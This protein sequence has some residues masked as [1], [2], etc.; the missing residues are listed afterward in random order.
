MASSVYAGW[1]REQLL[2]RVAELEK[3]NPAAA[4]SSSVP[5][6]PKPKPTKPFD[7]YS[8]PRRKI[9]LK[10][11]YAGWDYGGLAFQ[12]DDTPL[13]TVE[14]VL[15]DALAKAHLVDPHNQLGRL[16]LGTVWEDGS[17]SQWCQAGGFRVALPPNS[18]KAL[19]DG[20]EPP[21]GEEEDATVNV[22]ASDLYVPE[23]VQ[24][25][26]RSEHDYVSIL[27]RLLPETI[28][29]SAW[30]PVPSTFSARFSCNFR[31]YKYFFSPSGLNI[32]RMREGA[33]R[34]VGEHDFRNLCKLDP[35]KQIT[36]FK[37]NVMSATIDQLND[38][39]HVF[40]LTGSAFLYHQVR[41]IMA[42][43]FLIGTG[44]EQP[45]LV[46]NL[47]NVSSG[48]EP[49]LEGDAP[50]QVVDRK[51]EY[52]MADGLP[53]LLWDCGYPE[54]TFTWR[55][56]GKPDDGPIASGG[57]LHDQLENILVRSHI[58]SALNEHFF[59]AAAEHHPPPTS[60]FPL[61]SIE[62]LA[63]R[64]N[65]RDP[66][67]IHLG[68]GTFKRAVKYVP[69]L[70]RKRLDPVEVANERWRT[71]KGARKSERKAGTAGEVGDDP[72]PSEM[73]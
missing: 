59:L 56:T 40:N 26:S 72:S 25:Q 69:V 65:P 49:P 45:S 50:Y 19:V 55:T 61:S 36:S 71:G 35:A 67:N 13:P 18:R 43:L 42:V 44:L 24:P 57:A 28:R 48:E 38:N 32:S 39:V 52:Q 34:L 1:T 46:T 41:H 16:W 66:M 30:S 31:H 17:R 8:H 12:P 54:G 7:F 11:S 62:Q 27:N 29:V 58:Y 63:E 10:F 9:A 64:K 5:E 23:T 2:Q 73:L 68:G 21:E 33:S 6:A 60:L 47:L 22:N 70:Q 53:L 4:T 14:G 15:F 3:E 20:G 51:P 37:R